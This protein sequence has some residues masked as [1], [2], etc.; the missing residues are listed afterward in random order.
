MNDFIDKFEM[1]ANFEGLIKLL[2]KNLYTDS[3]VF[4]RELIQNAHD[5]IYLRKN[6]EKDH[7]G[8]IN[9]SIDYQNGI[10]VFSD[11][12]I[13]MD[14]K[15][16]K[17][18]LSVIGSTG[19]GTNKKALESASN[20]IALDLI[21]QFGIGMLSAFV[22]AD[23][24]Y[25]RTKKLGN[26]LS[27]EWR[28]NGTTVCELY[29]FNKETIGTDIIVYL[30]NDSKYMASEE[31]IRNVVLKYCDFLPDPILIDNRGPVNFMI[32][33]W[34]K[35][36]P[37]KKDRERGLSDYI[38]RKYNDYNLDIIDI[39]IDKEIKVNGIIYISS[40]NVLKRGGKGYIDIYIR[41]MLVKSNDTEL[42]PEWAKFYG[43]IIDTSS[44]QPTASRD[45]I[46]KSDDNYRKLKK[47]LEE[48]IINHL[49]S[50]YEND[51]EKFIQINIIHHNS[52]KDI[53]F[54]NDYF[55]DKIYDY[56]IFTTSK[57]ILST[58]EIKEKT[59]SDSLSGNKIFYYTDDPESLSQKYKKAEKENKILIY[60]DNR[61]LELLKKYERKKNDI[62]LK[63]FSIEDDYNRY[64]KIDLNTLKEYQIQIAEIKKILGKIGFN[65]FEVDIRDFNNSETQAEI[66]LSYNAKLTNEIKEL[67]DN[68]LDQN[69]LDVLNIISTRNVNK[70]NIKLFLLNFNNFIIKRLLSFNISGYE[71]EGMVASIFY[72]TIL[73]SDVAISPG[74]RTKISQYI[75]RNFILNY[76]NS[77][78]NILSTNNEIEH[79]RILLIDHTE[80]KEIKTNLKQFL[81]DSPLHIEAI[82]ELK[83]SEIETGLNY[84]MILLIKDNNS[85]L[86]KIKYYLNII[87][88]SLS[89][90]SIIINLNSNNEN[91][92]TDNNISI[93]NLKGKDFINLKNILINDKFFQATFEELKRI[94]KGRYLSK[95]VLSKL[96]YS[97]INETHI[98]LIIGNY[99]NI[100]KFVFEYPERISSITGLDTY[101]VI[102]LQGELK[103][104]K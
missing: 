72:S 60:I 29:S 49:I 39:N 3:D 54:F 90:K 19:T 43:G 71:Y 88:P 45:N 17:D 101:S 18:F 51:I 81:E 34:E 5:S 28:N 75:L 67:S 36:Y 7:S 64:K 59:Q 74:I 9:I 66:V 52:I 78:N 73:D 42:L 10:L 40:E 80:L 100:E 79:P 99:N 69:Y 70:D 31:W 97:K 92:E 24:V 12:G 68:V 23:K 96:K 56:I 84:D 15:D 20:I 102:T 95:D 32:P 41:R 98:D 48:V 53:A 1:R 77:T 82:S 93:Y 46:Q 94:K 89:I 86:T 14:E 50:L 55:F 87:D 58:K 21:G 6:I 85:D 25:V 103:D 63:K 33:P 13:G 35:K 8:A 62:I 11:N 76:G 57:G 65:D 30:N 61:E 22:V 27:F 44:L 104:F 47:E 91:I 4:V 26:N 83:N 2:A 16:I 37:S 38:I